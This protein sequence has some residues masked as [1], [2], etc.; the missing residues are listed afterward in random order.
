MHNSIDDPDHTPQPGKPPK[1]SSIMITLKVLILLKTAPSQ[2]PLWRRA[3]QKWLRE[4]GLIKLKGQ[5]PMI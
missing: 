2:K 4:H 5:T 3:G 1:S